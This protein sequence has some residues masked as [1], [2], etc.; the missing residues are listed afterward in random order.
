MFH[1]WRHN[2]LMLHN[3]IQSKAIFDIYVQFRIDWDQNQLDMTKIA[4]LW[5]FE[6]GEKVRKIFE[7]PKILRSSKG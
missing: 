3:L 5:Q 7:F 4:E 2:F 6:V 1:K